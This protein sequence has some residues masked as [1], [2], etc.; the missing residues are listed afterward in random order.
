MR[1]QESAG[2]FYNHGWLY[3]T[4]LQS[5]AWD[6]QVRGCIFSREEDE[7]LHY[8]RSLLCLALIC[9]EKVNGCEEHSTL[10]ACVCHCSYRP[11]R[12]SSCT[13]PAVDCS[14]LSSFFAKLFPCNHQNPKAAIMP[15]R[16]S[17]YHTV[18]YNSR[19]SKVA[20]EAVVFLPSIS[21]LPLIFVCLTSS[22]IEEKSRVLSQEAE[23][24]VSHILT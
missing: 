3:L 10:F 4:L 7:T 8:F 16:S 24:P 1:S 14:S 9:P 17:T 6:F 18:C 22:Q 20:P 11:V 5:H 21:A 2:L 19:K 13:S 23:A 12:E 15:H